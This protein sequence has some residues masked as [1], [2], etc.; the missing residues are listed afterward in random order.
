MIIFGMSIPISL[1]N[2]MYFF[3][4]SYVD[5]G[6]ESANDDVLR[7]IGKPHTVAQVRIATKWAK[8]AG[9]SVKAPFIS[10]LPKST[11]EIEKKYI[12]FFKEIGIDMPKIII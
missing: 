2:V 3:S 10:G 4:I 8:D 6:V 9:L 12:T 1:K 7:A 11:Y 5:F